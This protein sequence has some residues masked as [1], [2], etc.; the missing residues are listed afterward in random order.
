VLI[1]HEVTFIFE[2]VGLLEYDAIWIVFIFAEI[3]E[4]AASIFEVE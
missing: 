1:N 2:D 4:V 3:L